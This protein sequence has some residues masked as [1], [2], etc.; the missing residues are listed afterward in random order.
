[1]QSPHRWR[2]G[3]FFLLRGLFT[4]AEQQALVIEGARIAAEAPFVVPRMRDGTPFR[5]SV[6]AAGA[7]IFLSDRARGYHYSRQH[8]TTY[9]SLP[10]IPRLAHVLAHRALA[11][12]SCRS[13]TPIFDPSLI[14]D[15]MLLN[16][17]DAELGESLGLHVDEQELDLDAPLVTL[18]VGADCEFLVG[19]TDRDFKP[20]K[21]LVSGGDA[22]VMSGRSRLWHHAAKRIMPTLISPL[23]RGIRWAFLMRK[24]FR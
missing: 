23:P 16:R 7:G 15:T 19:D 21:A 17:Y 6:T 3:G 24:A 4:E 20:D 10:E 1:M 9:L 8:P 22:I 11:E 2:D 14:F 5:C 18:S 12:A 13:S